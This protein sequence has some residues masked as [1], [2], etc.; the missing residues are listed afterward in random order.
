[1]VVDGAPLGV[2]DPPSH[3]LDDGGSHPPWRDGGLQPV[4]SYTNKDSARQRP[5]DRQRIPGPQGGWA[6]EGHPDL[7]LHRKVLS[8]LWAPVE[9][10]AMATNCGWARVALQQAAHTQCARRGP[11]ATGGTLPN[12]H[13]CAPCWTRRGGVSRVGCALS[14]LGPG[15]RLSED[16]GPRAEPEPPFPCSRLPLLPCPGWR[17][18]VLPQ[19]P[20]PCLWRPHP[21]PPATLQPC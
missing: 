2:E 12:H 1:M 18:P 16:R 4:P 19:C 21:L 20:H 17:A 5:G 11:T 10:R 8:G 7:P 13:G 15:T 3:L 9:P 6:V 14:W